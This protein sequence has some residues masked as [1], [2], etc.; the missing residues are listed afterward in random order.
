MTITIDKICRYPV[1][2]LTAEL[3]T[4][5][6]LTPGQGLVSDR[7]FALTLGTTPVD[8]PTMA[9]MPKTAFLCLMLHAKLA[10]LTTRFDAETGILT[11]DRGGKSVTKGDITTPVGRAMIEEFFAAFMGPDA[12]GR[13][14]L[15]E[16]EP[17]AILSD[18]ADGVCSIINLASVRDLERVTGSEID[19]IRFRANIYL[20]GLEPWTEFDWVG[21][22]LNL[23][24]ATLNVIKRIDRCAAT[25]VNPSTGERDLKLLNDL[26]RGFGHVDMGIY[27]TVT[28]AGEIATGD[29]LRVSE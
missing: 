17:G 16:C 1:K 5:T 22:D 25:H 9:W 14:K 29:E 4:A 26:K 7:R 20:D 23:G 2:G 12:R 21:K 27:A 8:G 15:V 10:K 11:V 6:T 19:P 28:T 13:P 18:I 3:L 24:T